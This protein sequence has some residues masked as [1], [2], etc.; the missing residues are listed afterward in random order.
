MSP[1]SVDAEMAVLAPIASYRCLLRK[2]LDEGLRPEFLHSST[3]WLI[4]ETLG[5]LRV[6]MF[7]D[8]P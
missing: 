3:G 4:A 1:G 7:R 6:Q 5:V 2:V 8:K